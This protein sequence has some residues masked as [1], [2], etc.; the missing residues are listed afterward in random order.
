LIF[1]FYATIELGVASWIPTYSIKTA[2][3]DVQNSALYSLLFWLPNCLSR[4][5]WMYVPGT[6]EQR[7]GLSLKTVLI[8]SVLPVIF[9]YF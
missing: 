7:L 4:L 2:V 3:A 6:V 8:A 9:Q 1:F 5:G